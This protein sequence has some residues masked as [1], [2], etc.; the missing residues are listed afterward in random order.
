MIRPGKL[1]DRCE[2]MRIVKSKDSISR[3]VI[4]YELIRRMRGNFRMGKGSEVIANMSAVA[5]ARTE[6]QT[7]VRHGTLLTYYSKDANEELLIKINGTDVYE[8][9][10]FEHDDM[11][12]STI[13]TLRLHKK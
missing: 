13:W 4:S 10:T 2:L 9:V 8:V 3:P 7:N 5:G 6:Y 1:R 12:S 11:D